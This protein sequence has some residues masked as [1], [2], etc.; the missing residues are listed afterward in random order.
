MNSPNAL[1]SELKLMQRA[2]RSLL[3]FAVLCF[4]NLI[5]SQNYITNPGF[6]SHANINCIGCGIDNINELIPG[7]RSLGF[8]PQP[9]S[10]DYE[11][12]SDEIRKGYNAE[13]YTPH[14]G[15]GLCAIPFYG[16]SG[17]SRIG[18]KSGYLI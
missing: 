16:S 2:M 1:K 15:K 9:Y 12:S 7:W 17:T 8:F 18:G 13:I 6:E 10:A 3:T 4:A 5:V 11:Y 14:E